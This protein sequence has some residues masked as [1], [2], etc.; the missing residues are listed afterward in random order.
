MLKVNIHSFSYSEEEILNDVKF[1]LEAGNHLSI[2]GESGCGKSTLL[3]LIYGLLHLQNGEITN[4]GKLLLG[5]KNSLIPGEK[6]MKLLAQDFNLMPFSTVAENIGSHLTR[7]DEEADNLRITKLIETV[8]LNGFENKL[9]KTLSGG[10]KQR[11]ALAKAL[12]QEPQVLLLDEPFSNIDGFQKNEL[13]RNIYSYLKKNNISCITAT[14]DSEEALAFSDTICILKEGKI[15]SIGST[16]KIYN[17]A[18]TEYE[19]GFF[20]EVTKLSNRCFEESENNNELLFLPHQL[21]LS[22]VETKLKVQVVKSYFKGSHYLIEAKVDGS[23][24]FFN[25]LNSIDIGKII[26][27]KKTAEK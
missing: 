10:Q 19:L 14:H 18:S 15:Q 25:N 22:D 11:V 21:Q 20:G 3:H 16:E 27:L 12:A 24:V 13:R 2:L 7:L 6:F 5:P 1:S 8:N 17:K 23:S 26:Y 4:N 9:V